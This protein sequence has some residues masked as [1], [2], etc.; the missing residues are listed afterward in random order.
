[1]F[2][3]KNNLSEETRAKAV[4]LLNTRLADCI[5]LQTAESGTVPMSL[6]GLLHTTSWPRRPRG[7]VTS[8]GSPWRERRPKRSALFSNITRKRRRCA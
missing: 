5:D 8:I 4:E 6:E 2:K 7:G 3:T 1:M